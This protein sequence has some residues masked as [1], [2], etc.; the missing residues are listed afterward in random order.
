MKII[1]GQYKL[2]HVT[3]RPHSEDQRGMEVI[4]IE[5]GQSHFKDMYG[6]IWDTTFKTIDEDHIKMTA[7]VDQ[8]QVDMDHVLSAESGRASAEN[9]TYESLLKISRKDDS[10][11]LSGQIEIGDDI[12]IIS[13]HKVT[14]A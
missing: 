8:S 7:Q 11:H 9:L 1:S 6:C 2:Q 5:N 10:I 4:Q 13:L 14:N 12:V 3:S